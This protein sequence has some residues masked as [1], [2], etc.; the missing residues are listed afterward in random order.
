MNSRHLSPLALTLSVVVW[1][2]CVTPQHK[3]AT[4]ETP[5]PV[6]LNL[7]ATQLRLEATLHH[8]ILFH[9]PGSWKLDAK[10]DEYVV[11]VANRGTGP[12]VLESAT[13]F[14]HADT[15][16]ASSADPWTLEKSSAQ[17]LPKPHA[18][19]KVQK[20]PSAPPASGTSPDKAEPKPSVVV[21]AGVVVAATAVVAVVVAAPFYWPATAGLLALTGASAAGNAIA[22]QPNKEVIEK[23]FAKRRLILP[24][25]IAPADTVSGSLFF[26]VAPEPLRLVLR[27]QADGNPV[28]LAVDLAPLGGMHAKALTSAR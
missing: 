15:P 5:P 14:D 13:L 18:I 9:G 1:S 19:A 12:F 26:T 27:G 10:W 25:T 16:L 6:P 21:R 4:T 20:P 7:T 24:T 8:V 2:G 3:L 28:E 22:S 11:S 17:R 23:E